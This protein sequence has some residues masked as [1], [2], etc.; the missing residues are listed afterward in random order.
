MEKTINDSQTALQSKLISQNIISKG[1]VEVKLDIGAHTGGKFV[2]NDKNQTTV[3]IG[4]LDKQI[5]SMMDQTD[6]MIRM[7]GQDFRAMI[8]KVCGKEAKKAHMK[9]HRGPPHCRDFTQL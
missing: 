6:N 1:C 8:C 3:E 9:E 4:Q 7:G 2:E 5:C